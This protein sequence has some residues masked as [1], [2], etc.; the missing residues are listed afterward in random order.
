MWGR[1]T[2]R[3]GKKYYSLE[4]RTRYLPCF[5]ELHG[6][7]Y[8]NKV[9]VVPDNIYDL[10]TPIALAHWIMGDGAI[11]NKGLILCTD[12]FT[13]QDNVKECVEDKIWT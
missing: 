9:K 6:F 3:K 11:R 10:L 5:N 7:F 13:L 12:S 8:K 1:R 4:F 2:S